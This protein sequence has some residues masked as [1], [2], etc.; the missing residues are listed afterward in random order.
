MIRYNKLMMVCGKI[1]IHADHE[2]KQGMYRI[3]PP[4]EVI[5]IM[6]VLTKQG[7]EA[8]AVGGCIRDSVMGREPKDWDI[9]TSACPDAVKGVFEKTLDTGLSHGTVTVMIGGRSYEVTTFRIDG[10]YEDGRHPEYVKFTGRLEDDLRRRDFTI[11]SMA[12]NQNRGIVD[13]FGG[14]GDIAAGVVRAVGLPP[15]R[16]REDALRMLRAVRFAARL[17]F[18]IEEATFDAIKS[19]CALIRKISAE[20]IREELTG[21]LTSDDPAKFALLAETGLLGQILGKFGYGTNCK[22]VIPKGHCLSAVGSVDADVCLR[23][24]MLFHCFA[25]SVRTLEHSGVIDAGIR[26]SY[27]DFYAAAKDIMLKLKFSNKNMDR[28]LRLLKYADIKI[29]PERGSVARAASCAGED[30]FGDLLKLKR[31]AAQTM[32]HDG[33]LGSD[34][35]AAVNE[36]ERIYRDLIASGH[37]LKLRDLAVNGHDL[38]RLGFSEGSDIGSALSYLLGRVIEEPGLNRKDVLEMMALDYLENG[39][40][41]DK[42]N[43]NERKG[44]NGRSAEK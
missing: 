26:A 12:W 37:C 21:I 14:M 35:I 6:D 13:P 39:P 31:A 3:D 34:G 7:Y 17:G 2:R 11:N 22:S 32:A 25:V 23:W 19:N 10:R 9:T 33:E 42:V 18:G 4:G 36:I 28:I 40:E 1:C 15:E 44:I 29:T 43:S 24:A 5:Y 41:K 16:F 20:R 27:G 30:I 38:M 8:Y